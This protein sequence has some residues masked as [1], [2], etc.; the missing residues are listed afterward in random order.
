MIPTASQR[1]QIFMRNGKR[2]KTMAIVEIQA[3]AGIRE[4]M[5]VTAVMATGAAREMETAH[6]MERI[7]PVRP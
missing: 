3:T 7:I 5:A 1:I 4:I 2:R 6:R